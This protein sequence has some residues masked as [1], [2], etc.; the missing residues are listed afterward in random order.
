M[1][2]NL[3]GMAIEYT[4][5]SIQTFFLSTDLFCFSSN[6]WLIIPLRKVLKESNPNNIDK[7]LET[8]P[9]FAAQIIPLNKQLKILLWILD[10]WVRLALDHRR[11]LLCACR[12]NIV[13]CYQRFDYSSTASWSPMGKQFSTRDG[14]FVANMSR[15]LFFLV[16]KE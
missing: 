3:A 6:P 10:R 14:R 11:I 8:L 4:G 12:R 2:S 9:T 1:Q 13:S 16:G 5:P 15:V 7:L